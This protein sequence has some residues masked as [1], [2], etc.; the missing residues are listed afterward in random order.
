[1]I[2]YPNAKINLGL[3]VVRKRSDGFHDIESVFYPIP[4]YDILE[5]VPESKGSGRVTFTSSGIDIPSDGKPNL[6]E[7]VYQLMHDEFDLFSVKMHLHKIVPIGAGLGGGSAD[8]AFAAAM[9]NDMFDL[10]LSEERL[11]AIVSQ[12]GSDCPFFIRNKPAYVTGRGEVL[13]PFDLDLSGY[14]IIL[15]NPNI[16]I[17]TKE[18][19]AGITPSEP[20][21]SLKELLSKDVSEWKNGVK[22]DFEASIFPNH[23]AIE[24]LKEQ[25][26]ALGADYASMTGSGSTVFGLFE[27]Q[28]SDVKFSYGYSVKIAQL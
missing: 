18:A 22:N 7:R 1:M 8:A 24:K 9:L 16:H 10:G 5:I 2:G 26:Y 25:L 12:V 4:W 15:V 14:W 27:K 6:C 13:E 11:E 3:N 23:P 20:E 21:F 19:Y 17:G 28:P